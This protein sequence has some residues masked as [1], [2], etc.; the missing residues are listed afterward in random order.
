MANATKSDLRVEEQQS[1]QAIL[2]RL[3]GAVEK[4]AFGVGVVY[5]D[6]DFVKWC[7]D[8]FNR[9]EPSVPSLW[10][11]VRILESQVVGR[12]MD[13]DP[14]HAERTLANALLFSPN[15]RLFTYI[16]HPWSGGFL[17]TWSR[18]QAIVLARDSK[19]SD[20]VWVGSLPE[21][22]LTWRVD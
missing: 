2:Q 6:A 16:R 17:I 13:E 20:L 10:Q 3:R 7:R 1:L 14:R 4:P 21:Y 18:D 5:R 11:P 22:L 12:L 15:V 19:E 9:I 8:V